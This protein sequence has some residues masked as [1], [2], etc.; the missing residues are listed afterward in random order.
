METRKIRTERNK[1]KYLILVQ[2]CKLLMGANANSVEVQP[3]YYSNRQIIVV[4]HS[5]RISKRLRYQGNDDLHVQIFKAKLLNLKIYSVMDT[6][7]ESLRRRMNREVAAYQKKKTVKY[8]QFPQR[9]E[10][11]DR[12][13]HDEDQTDPFMFRTNTRLSFRPFSRYLE[14][15]NPGQQTLICK[16]GGGEQR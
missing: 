3:W 11:R 7:C 5:T 10:T 14:C 1:T 15:P 16:G 6:Y 9:P 4:S 12:P 13:F 2:N 8:F